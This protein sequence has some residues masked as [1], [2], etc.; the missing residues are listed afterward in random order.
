MTETLGLR[1]AIRQFAMGEMRV[2]ALHDGTR[3]QEPLSPPFCLDKSEAEL[4]EIGRANRLPV[5]GNRNSFTPMLVE[6]GAHK[7]LVDVGFGPDARGTGVGQVVDGLALLGLT[8]EDITEVML[9]HMHPDHIL[10][11]RHDGG[12]TFPKASYVMGRVEYDSWK[13]GAGV[14]EQRQKNREMFLNLVVP[15]AGQTRFLEDGETVVPGMV[16]EAA[17]GHSPGH[18]M[19]RLEGGGRQALIWG[20]L[21]NHYVFSVRYP[22]SP[23]GYDD[24]KDRAIAS[25][26]RVLDMAATD[27]LLVLG[28]HMPFPAIGF[29][30]RYGSAYRWVPASYQI[31]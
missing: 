23:V 6:S 25:R 27:D 4:A 20:D 9:T 21:A 19:A 15:L 7:V 13:S 11:L 3:W 10:G 24:D 14:P 16:A 31:D 5:H 12:P 18:M 2:T 1:P 28:H 29:I 22:D 26:R 30:E 17:F 8:P